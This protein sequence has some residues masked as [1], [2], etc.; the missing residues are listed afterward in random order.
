MRGLEKGVTH[1]CLRLPLWY[2][3]SQKIEESL[4]GFSVAFGEYCSC[5][6][7]HL[8]PLVIA[9]IVL[10]IVVVRWLESENFMRLCEWLQAE[11]RVHLLVFF[12]WILSHP[13]GDG[14][15][16]LVSGEI[17]EEMIDVIK[18]AAYF[19]ADSSHVVFKRRCRRF[20][21]SHHVPGRKVSVYGVAK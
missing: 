14:N 16:E 20:L 12:N 10:L 18:V 7:A 6:F 2:V 5:F 4:V 21:T 13:F 1:A 8:V 15:V 11:K 3:F 17:S 19:C 9:Y